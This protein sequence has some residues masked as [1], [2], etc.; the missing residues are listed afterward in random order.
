MVNQR[1]KPD[2]AP[3]LRLE[4]INFLMRSPEADD[5]DFHD[6]DT[7]HLRLPEEVQDLRPS[8][9]HTGK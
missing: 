3:K 6:A 4:C 9:G 8:G 5:Q 1:P 7:D 2:K